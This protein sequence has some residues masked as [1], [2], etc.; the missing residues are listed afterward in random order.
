MGLNRG[1]DCFDFAEPLWFLLAC[2]QT[3]GVGTRWETSPA[4][5]RSSPFAGEVAG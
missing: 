5:E 3:L 4:G 1:G 2:G